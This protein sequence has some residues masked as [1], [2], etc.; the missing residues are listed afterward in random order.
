MTIGV[1]FVAFDIVPEAVWIPVTIAVVM[2]SDRYAGGVL[3]KSVQRAGATV[4]GCGLGLGF[5]LLHTPHSALVLM[6]VGAVASFAAGY[7]LDDK[8]FAYMAMYAGI[9]LIIVVSIPSDQG[10]EFALWRIANIFIGGAIGLAVSVLVLPESAR[11]HFITEWH[12]TLQR[13]EALIDRQREGVE[14]PDHLVD[15]EEAIITGVRR[16]EATL[17]SARMEGLRWRRAAPALAD[18]I[19]RERELVRHLAARPPDCNAEMLTNLRVDGEDL[20]IPL[21]PG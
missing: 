18:L 12:A 14:N 3:K 10:I 20:L 13:I 15:D 4:I 19:R 2:S 11:R 21:R 1:A 5:L 8:R 7:L 9:S 17:A 6:V 16:Q